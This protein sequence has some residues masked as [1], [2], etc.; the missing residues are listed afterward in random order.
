MINTRSSA[1]A[2]YESI[3]PVILKPYSMSSQINIKLAS[4]IIQNKTTDYISPCLTPFR[5]RKR[6]VVPKFVLALLFAFSY[7]LSNRLI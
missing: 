2:I 3:I 1:N 5:S 4:R 6:F 7:I